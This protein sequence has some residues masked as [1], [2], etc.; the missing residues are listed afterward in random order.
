MIVDDKY[1]IIGSANINDR[2]LLGERDSEIA[3]LF[4]DKEMIKSKM[5]GKEVE[6]GKFSQSLRKRLWKEH[7]T[8]IDVTRDNKIGNEKLRKKK[9]KFIS[10]KLKKK[11]NLN[12]L[13]FDEN[14]FDD[15]ICDEIYFNCWKKISN[16]NTK[17]FHQVFKSIVPNE[18][19]SNIST[20]IIEREKEA[21]KWN[22]MNE[23]EK[24]QFY[25]ESKKNLKNI[26]GFLCDYK[27]ILE[28]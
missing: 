16:E 28:K 7:L 22:L 21:G 11:E 23:K 13:K 14:L 6:V 3:I 8:N 1:S 12:L 27:K 17:I 10:E 15:A 20:Y 2:S 19:M 5:D 26:N 24:E 25:K 18:D 4:E 9:R